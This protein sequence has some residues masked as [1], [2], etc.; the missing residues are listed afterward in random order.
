MRVF[1]KISMFF[2]EGG[3]GEQGFI[4]AVL[5][6]SIFEKRLSFRMV[7][8][9]KNDHKI[10][11]QWKWGSGGNV[12]VVVGP[13]WSPSGGSGGKASDLIMSGWYIIANNRKEHSRLIYFECKL[14][15]NFFWYA[16]KIKFYEDWVSKLS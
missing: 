6:M 12:N 14:R 9:M 15:A 16:S 8:F 4:Q 7:Y 1:N 10:I 3:R 5:P 2:F 11:L 13:W